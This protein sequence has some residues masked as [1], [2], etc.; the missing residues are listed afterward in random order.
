[1]KKTIKGGTGKKSYDKKRKEKKRKEKE[2]KEEKKRF[3][4]EERARCA[5]Q[6]W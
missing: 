2:E 4:S 1:M 5:G 6:D 3:K